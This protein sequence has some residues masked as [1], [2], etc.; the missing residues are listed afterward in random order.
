MALQNCSIWNM[1]T[2]LGET[3]FIPD[4]QR[5]YS[6]EADELGDFWDDLV[7]TKKDPDM[8]PHFFGQVVVHHDEQAK[9]I[10]DGQQR[11]ITSALSEKKQKPQPENAGKPWTSEDDSTLSQMYEEGKTRKE[12]C[13]YFKRSTGGIASRL[14][15]LGKIP[16]RDTFRKKD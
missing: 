14:V 11:T 13:E 8:A 12:I 4:Y 15:R 10:I 6:W 2:Y 3:Y 16:A 7:A 9:Y 5:E 1:K